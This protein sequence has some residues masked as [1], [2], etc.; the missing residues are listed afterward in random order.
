M[1][2]TEQSDTKVT[3]QLI[4]QPDINKLGQN[5][6]IINVED[7]QLYGMSPTES[8]KSENF[9]KDIPKN[10]LLSKLDQYLVTN[11][12]METE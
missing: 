1:Y 8:I 4:T 2:H 7:G 9:E 11:K 10:D 3:N 5:N 12:E 6:E